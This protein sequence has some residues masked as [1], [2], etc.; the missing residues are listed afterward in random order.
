MPKLEEGKTT[1]TFLLNGL[2][3]Q[4]GKF[5]IKINGVFI[6][7]V[8]NSDGEIDDRNLANKSVL[9][10]WTDDK[11][12][13]F[14]T[15]QLFLDYAERVI[16]NQINGTNKLAF[17]AWGRPKS[18]ID[19]SIFH[20]LFT[21]NVPVSIWYERFNGTILTTFTRATSVNGALNI[22]AGAALNDKTNLRTFR[23]P[24][25]EP[26]RGFLYSTAGIIENPS[27]LMNRRFGTATDE[28]GVFFSLESGVLY[29][30]IR[31]TRNGVTTEDKILLDVSEVNLSKG[32]VFDIQFQWRGVGNYAFFI[33]L[34]EV[35]NTK[36][37]GTLTELSLAN[38][39]LP[40][41]FESVN[42]GNNNKMVFGCVDVTSE[43][44]KTN[45]K[46]YGSVNIS[47]NEGEVSISG[48]NVPI[49]AI[50]SKTTVN[51]RINT[52]DTLA[53]LASAYA[54]V[55]AIFRVWATRDFT[56]ITQNNQ[57]WKNFGDG[58]LEYIEYNNPSVASPMTFNTAKAQL[59]FGAR[60]AIDETYN[61][62]ALFEGRTDIYLAPSD[63]FI[64]TVHKEGGT[65]AKAGVTFEFAE[66]I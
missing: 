49:I 19:N 64:F 35:G 46:T 28:N 33:N 9:A 41:F 61:T 60:V 23:N 32:N 43:G 50:R 18:V 24:R 56:A 7:I 21:F 30:V 29:G 16:Y 27:A 31:T 4:K 25:Y 12:N 44:G 13:T 37:L 52:R 15:L 58:H 36:Y 14:A 51:G 66:E 3:Y 42:L 2:P 22:T 17:D 26:N 59:I 20:A 57:V 53:L 48:Y 34:K 47:N 54:N 63:M 10:D 40:L 55:K 45:G 5:E 1:G 8:R 6:S 62:S 11:N 39:A 38:P 65:Q